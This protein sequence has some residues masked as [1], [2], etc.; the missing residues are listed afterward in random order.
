V[1]YSPTMRAVLQRVKKASVTVGGEIIG[2]VGV[3]LL[4]LVAIHKDDTLKDLDW[5]A[6]KI[7]NLRIFEDGDGKM[8]LSVVD[9]GGGL[10][11]VSQFTL[12]GDCKKGRRPSFIDSMG[13]E[14]AAKM[15]D[16]L[17]E[18][19]RQANIPT[20]T[21]RFGADMEVELLNWGPVTIILDS[22]R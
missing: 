18:R 13:P 10:L 20:E 16:Q 11:V 17:V 9:A 1:V 3:G 19:F 4:A 22:P 2:R 5:M 8:N 14:P 12:Y 6:E 7:P 21:G 15:I